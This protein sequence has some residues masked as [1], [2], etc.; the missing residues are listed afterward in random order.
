MNIDETLGELKNQ[1]DALTAA[2]TDAKE[3][4][5]RKVYAA[6]RDALS[7]FRAKYGKVIK[8]LDEVAATGKTEV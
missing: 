3:N 5:S 1:H 2:Y 8:A 4:G 6:A 7:A